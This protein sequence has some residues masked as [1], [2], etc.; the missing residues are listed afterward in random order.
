MITTYTMVAFGGKR[1]AESERIMTK[2]QE[3]EWGLIL[4]DEVHVVPAA[5]FRKVLTVTPAHCKLGLTGRRLTDSFWGSGSN[6]TK[7]C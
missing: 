1:S 7:W 6:S 2:M 4:L 3:R 5:M